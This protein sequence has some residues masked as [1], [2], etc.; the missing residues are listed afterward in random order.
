MAAAEDAG[1]GDALLLLSYPLHPPGKAN[2]LRTEHFAKLHVPAMFAHGTRDSFG[3]ID[4]MRAAVAA[5][6][7]VTELLAI[8]GA[9][10]GLPATAA[11]LVASRFMEFTRR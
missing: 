6:P 10:H 11:K 5:I 4:E 8:D 2:Q 7:A 9:P 1:I 3:T